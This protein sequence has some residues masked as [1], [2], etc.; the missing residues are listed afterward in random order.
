MGNRAKARKKCRESE[1]FIRQ[2]TLVIYFAHVLVG[3]VSNVAPDVVKVVPPESLALQWTHEWRAVHT[4][5][6]SCCVAHPTFRRRR[7]WTRTVRVQRELSRAEH[8]A[9]LAHQSHPTRP[10]VYMRIHAYTCAMQPGNY[11][12][13]AGRFSERSSKLRVLNP[14]HVMIMFLNGLTADYK[15]HVQ[16]GKT[17]L[18][19]V[20]ETCHRLALAARTIQHTR[21][22]VLASVQRA[23][24]SSPWPMPTLI[25]H[26]RRSGAGPSRKRSRFP[27]RARSHFRRG[28][29]PVHHQ[30]PRPRPNPQA[31]RTTSRSPVIRTPN[32]H[33]GIPPKSLPADRPTLLKHGAAL[34]ASPGPPG[35]QRTCICDTPFLFW[36]H[37]NQ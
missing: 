28:S 25:S 6:L 5:S 34:H 23:R 12:T 11:T 7:R 15:Q 14:T 17:S 26:G 35:L 3:I 21:P 18:A 4:H 16:H 20:Q 13:N 22:S 36:K 27:E 29:P 1:K 31:V 10:R 24:G 37:A 8:V 33:D 32:A 9:H 30:F 2:P 19:D